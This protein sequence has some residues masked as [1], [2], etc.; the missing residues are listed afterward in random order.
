MSAAETLDLGECESR[1]DLVEKLQSA[2]AFQLEALERGFP[3]WMPAVIAER[4]RVT[5]LDE[6]ALCE[7]VLLGLGEPFEVPSC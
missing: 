7:E 2:R 1:E 3:S 4:L 6:V 5:R